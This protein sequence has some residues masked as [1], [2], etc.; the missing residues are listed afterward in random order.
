MNNSMIAYDYTTH[1][2]ERYEQPVAVVE[3]MLG[4]TIKDVLIGDY[5]MQDLEWLQEDF[6]GDLESTDLINQAFKYIAGDTSIEKLD[7]HFNKW[8]A[9]KRVN[10]DEALEGAM[11]AAA[12]A[13]IRLSK[14]GEHYT[15]LPEA[16]SFVRARLRSFL[17]RVRTEALVEVLDNID[18]HW[19]LGYSWYVAASSY[20]MYEILTDQEL[21]DEC[22]G[23]L[24]N[25]TEPLNVIHPF[26]TLLESVFSTH[27]ANFVYN[28]MLNKDYGSEEKLA[29]YAL[30][31]FIQRDADTITQEELNRASK[32]WNLDGELLLY[33]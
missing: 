30:T 21:S 19:V 11:D 29:E 9:Y 4:E 14:D 23:D 18:K 2:G 3:H 8:K 17:L 33:V 10:L 27:V 7:D 25:A 1:S 6:S 13:G 5:S 12:E 24:G 15:F 20:G 32:T 31:R 22:Y 28:Y 16:R 26:A